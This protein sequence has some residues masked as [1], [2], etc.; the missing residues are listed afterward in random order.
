MPETPC[1]ATLRRIGRSR[2]TGWPISEPTRRSDPAASPGVCATASGRS[3]THH[4][5][6]SFEYLPGAEP[7]LA[8]ARVQG[9]PE[10]VDAM[11]APVKAAF[12]FQRSVLF[13]SWGGAQS[14]RVAEALRDL[15]EPKVPPGA[16]I[17][18]SPEIRPGENPLEEMMDRNLRVADAHI[19]VVT[20]DAA[21]RH[22]VTWEVASS[23]GRQKP[24]IPLFVGVDPNKVEGPLQHLV[25][26][27]KLDDA[28]QLTRA[29]EVVVSAVGGQVDSPLSAE[30]FASLKRAA[31]E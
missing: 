1:G 20:P 27:V 25:Q 21:K 15:L 7:P 16:D 12:P 14:R 30:E 31:A 24:V 18:F 5:E 11:I 3:K 13:L 17:F 29:I 22:W 23:W 9:P 2:R 19:V 10:E 6:C 26:G 8:Q 28:K 4:L